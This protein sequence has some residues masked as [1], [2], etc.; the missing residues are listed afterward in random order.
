MDRP[1]IDLPASPSLIRRW[2]YQTAVQVARALNATASIPDPRV[3]LEDTG[4][5]VPHLR[6]GGTRSSG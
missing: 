3:P 5:S 6:A 2:R 4:L 1:R